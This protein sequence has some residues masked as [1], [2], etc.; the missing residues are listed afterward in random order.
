M[1]QLPSSLPN[2]SAGSAQLTVQASKALQ[3][4]ANTK[5]LVGKLYT[6][7]IDRVEGQKVH[8]SL[9]G[10]SM[11]AQ[12][13]LPLQAGTALQVKVTQTH[14]TV[15]LQA[16]VTKEPPQQM[17]AQTAYRQLLPNQMP[18]NQGLQQLVQLAQSPA[19]PSVVQTGLTQ[20]FEQLFRPSTQLTSQQL[21]QQLQGTGLF[22]ENRLAQGRPPVATDFK[23]K[24]LQLSQ[25]LLGFKDEN[26]ETEKLSKTLNQT[27]NRLTLQQ[28]QAA[29]NP[30]TI[31][32]ELPLHPESRLNPIEID[33]RRQGSAA[34]PSWEVM[35][36]LTLPNG[37]LKA[38]VVYQREQLNAGL[39]S[40]TSALKQSLETQLPEL[41]NQFQQA[42]LPLNHLFIAHQEPSP[43]QTAKKVALIDIHI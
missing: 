14:P 18:V 5:L 26:A 23:A 8:F 19:L 42:G 15:V 41:R 10:K 40:D 27:L 21:K 12:T 36:D 3:E 22:L 30:H 29:Q 38:K 43:D 13:N 24:L 16:Q 11:V 20:L 4:L 35:V 7:Q 1:A 28:L 17:A 25:L 33:I 6:A 34:S 9:A 32:I 37:R 2:A 31:N 39:W